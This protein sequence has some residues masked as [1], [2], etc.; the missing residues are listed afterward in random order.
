MNV[1]QKYTFSMTCS[2]SV[3]RIIVFLV[4]MWGKFLFFVLLFVK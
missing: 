1:V 2:K 4:E 3:W